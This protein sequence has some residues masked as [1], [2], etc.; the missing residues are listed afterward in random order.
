[1]WYCSFLAQPQAIFLSFLQDKVE[2]VDENH[3]E[4]FFVPDRVADELAGT[5]GFEDTECKD[6]RAM[7]CGSKLKC[8]TILF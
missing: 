5:F 1:M 7:A 3:G 4:E 6:D 8:G 2:R